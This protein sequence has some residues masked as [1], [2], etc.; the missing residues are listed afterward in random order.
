[1]HMKFFTIEKFDNEGLDKFTNFVN[2]YPDDEQIHIFL[3]SNWGESPI[4]DAYVLVIN[5]FKNKF[6][7]SVLI[8]SSSAFLLTLEIKCEIHILKNAYAMSHKWV[9]NVE[10]RD[11]FKYAWEF[12]A[13]QHKILEEAKTENLCYMTNKEQALYNEW[14]DVFFTPQRLWEIF[15]SV[16]KV[17][18][19]EK[20]L[21]K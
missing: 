5:S 11:W 21:Y 10:M 4:R 20:Y 18:D 15:I 17:Y 8:A 12:S 3:N 14:R 9:W 16:W 2:K 13:F 6:S 1:M 19:K 7:L